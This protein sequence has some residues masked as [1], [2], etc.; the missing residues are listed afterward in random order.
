[1]S[2]DLKRQVPVRP[3]NVM[4]DAYEQLRPGTRATVLPPKERTVKQ[5]EEDWGPEDKAVDSPVQPTEGEVLV[6]PPPQSSSVPPPLGGFVA[7]DLVRMLVIG[8]NQEEFPIVSK[9]LQ[10]GVRILCR[11]MYLNALNTRIVQVSEALGVPLPEARNE[12]KVQPVQ[13]KKGRKRVSTTG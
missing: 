9:E 13:K 6:S 1:M 8:D 10:Q 12:Q 7:I 5:Y 2:D 3:Q 4:A 11:D